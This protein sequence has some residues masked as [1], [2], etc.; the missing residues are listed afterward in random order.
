M[1]NVD[2][3][4]KVYDEAERRENSLYSKLAIY[5]AFVIVSMV[6]PPVFLPIAYAIL[7]APAPEKWFLILPAL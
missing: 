3:A 6:I 1:E 7:K 5:I 2:D 4:H